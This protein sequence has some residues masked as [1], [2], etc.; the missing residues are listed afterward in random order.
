[1]KEKEITF[2]TV[3]ILLLRKT[4]LLLPLMISRLSLRMSGHKFLYSCVTTN[5]RKQ[6]LTKKRLIV[7]SFNEEYIFIRW[8]FKLFVE[9]SLYFYP[10]HSMKITHAFRANGLCFRSS[11][12]VY[13]KRNTSSNWLFFTGGLH[14]IMSSQQHSG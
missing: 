7:E 1:M 4:D 11:D 8:M 6:E 2:N 12:A 13:D 5:G 14:C 3:K 10:T 9:F